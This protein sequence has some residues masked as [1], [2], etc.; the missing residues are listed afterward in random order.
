MTRVSGQVGL[1]HL[2]RAASW[3]DL[4]DGREEG[5]GA[6]DVSSSFIDGAGCDDRWDGWDGGLLEAWRRLVSTISV[7][8]GQ[9]LARVGGEVHGPAGGSLGYGWWGASRN[10]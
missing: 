4:W 10:R 3:K 6:G 1:G 8:V 2:R 5:D 9:G 7:V